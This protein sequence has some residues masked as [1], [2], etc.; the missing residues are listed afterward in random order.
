[1]KYLVIAD[2]WDPDWTV[3]E[4]TSPAEAIM[5]FKRQGHGPAAAVGE[6]VWEAPRSESIGTPVMGISL[7]SA[8]IGDIVEIKRTS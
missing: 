8:A 5:R 2:D 4:A 6:L 3:I 1:M 7:A